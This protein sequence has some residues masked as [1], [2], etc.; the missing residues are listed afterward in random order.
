LTLQI[1]KFER[2]IISRKDILTE[3]PTNPFLQD[4]ARP[5]FAR[6]GTHGH[7]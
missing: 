3:V 2:V 4:I 7:S 6:D 1:E 5:L